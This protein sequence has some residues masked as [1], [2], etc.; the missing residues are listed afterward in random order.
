LILWGTPKAKAAH[1]RV[2][3][4]ETRKRGD[5]KGLTHAARVT[6][7]SRCGTSPHVQGCAWLKNFPDALFEI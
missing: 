2:P 6:G 1:W 4:P 3:D 5:Q 7:E